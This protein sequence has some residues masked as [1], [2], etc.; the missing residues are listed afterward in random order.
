MQIAY[1]E[2]R[3]EIVPFK[4]FLRRNAYRIPRG[5]NAETGNFSLFHGLCFLMRNEQR[6][7]AFLCLFSAFHAVRMQDF[8]RTQR[9]SR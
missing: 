6:I 7:I 9:K 5:N 3:D 8:D 2:K 1:S 4:A